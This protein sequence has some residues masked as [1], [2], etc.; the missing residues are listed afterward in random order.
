MLYGLWVKTTIFF[1]LLYKVFEVK[2]NSFLPFSTTTFGTSCG[3]ETNESIQSNWICRNSTAFP[4]W[5]SIYRISVDWTCKIEVQS[6]APY[7]RKKQFI[8]F[9]IPFK[10]TLKNEAIVKFYGSKNL[11][12]QTVLQLESGNTAWTWLKI[13]NYFLLYLKSLL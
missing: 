12:R 13:Q 2:T 3:A 10:N 11:I 1:I 6:T 4:T 9:T 7:R 8:L 5:E